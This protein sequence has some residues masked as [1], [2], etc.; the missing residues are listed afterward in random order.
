LKK[1]LELKKKTISKLN[2]RI[3]D[4]NS[5]KD[6]LRNNLEIVNKQIMNLEKSENYNMDN[7]SRIERE[8]MKLEM[9]NMELS[10]RLQKVE[11]DLMTRT[12]E[13]DDLAELLAKEK[14]LL[15][16]S[17]KK[18]LINVNKIVQLENDAQDKNNELAKI[19]I[20]FEEKIRELESKENHLKLKGNEILKI[21]QQI[22]QM[23]K[24]PKRIQEKIKK[25]HLFGMKL[26]T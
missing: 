5:E 2:G 22:K 18:S 15:E 14:E 26:N 12:K 19:K 17:K 6:E 1:D 13:K 11:F 7:L 25:I 20:Q 3:E 23:N 21:K 16:A 9:S 10:E 4:L 24:I 8:K